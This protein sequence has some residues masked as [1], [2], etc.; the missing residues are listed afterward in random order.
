VAV[1]GEGGLGSHHRSEPWVVWVV[2]TDSSSPKT[3]EIPIFR[4]LKKRER[5]EFLGRC[6]SQILHVDHLSARV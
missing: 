4:I 1:V 3:D 2:S 6:L 5:R